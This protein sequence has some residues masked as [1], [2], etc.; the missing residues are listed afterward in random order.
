MGIEGG[1]VV[2]DMLAGH[3]IKDKQVN[4]IYIALAKCEFYSCMIVIEK[5]KVV[6]EELEQKENTAEETTSDE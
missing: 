3:V 2:I 1:Q 4:G 6:Q 5:N